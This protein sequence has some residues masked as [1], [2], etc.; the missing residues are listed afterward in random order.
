MMMMM[1]MMTCG[2]IYMLNSIFL[3]STLCLY[4]LTFSCEVTLC[5]IVCQKWD[6]E[7]KEW[8]RRE[9]ET[10]RRNEE[11]EEEEEEEENDE[12][13]DDEDDDDNT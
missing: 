6:S 9:E 12:E 1:M 2:T 11:E 13:D 10:Q 3:I 7:R 8:E 4:S 5:S